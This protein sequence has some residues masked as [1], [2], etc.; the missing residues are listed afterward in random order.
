MAAGDGMERARGVHE[1][2]EHISPAKHYRVRES[3]QWDCQQGI[4]GCGTGKKGGPAPPELLG[5]G[6]LLEAFS[7]IHLSSSEKGM[8]IPA[9]S[10]TQEGSAPPRA[11]PPRSKGWYL[12]H[13]REAGPGK[14]RKQMARDT[15][16]LWPGTKPLQ[17]SVTEDPHQQGCM[18]NGVDGALKLILARWG[19]S[20]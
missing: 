6:S 20:D 14:P 12:E 2:R 11:L 7:L 18:G 10:Q 5:S 15:V 16:T 1:W 3:Q 9:L 4:P 17:V 13:S 19:K 8:L